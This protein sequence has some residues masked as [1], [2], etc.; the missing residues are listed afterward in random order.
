MPSLCKLQTNS[1]KV[2]LSD[3][4]CAPESRITQAYNHAICP[5]FSKILLKLSVLSADITITISCIMSVSGVMADVL[6]YAASDYLHI[7][8]T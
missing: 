3:L 8:L 1:A 7:F 4:T 5:G 2:Q 6:F